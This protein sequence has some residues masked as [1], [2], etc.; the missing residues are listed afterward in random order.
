MECQTCRTDHSISR[1][2]A[3]IAEIK[4]D[5]KGLEQQLAAANEKLRRVREE[6]PRIRYT[7]TW[8]EMTE[9]LRE[10]D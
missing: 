6:W 5:N 1:V 3:M 10:D 7:M 8:D 4:E 9:L 2:H